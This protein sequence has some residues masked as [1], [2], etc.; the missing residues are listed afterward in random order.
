M[1]NVN[2]SGSFYDTHITRM[3]FWRKVVVR[4][5]LWSRRDFI[6]PRCPFEQVLK[7]SGFRLNIWNWL[8]CSSSVHVMISDSWAN[9]QCPRNWKL[10]NDTSNALSKMHLQKNYAFTVAPTTVWHDCF[11]RMSVREMPKLYILT[12]CL[13]FVYR[14]KRF[15]FHYWCVSDWDW[16]FN[17]TFNDISVM[18]RHIYRCAGG[19]KKKKLGLRSG[20]NR[21]FV[22]FSC[23]SKHQHHHVQPFYGYS[24]NFSCL[25]RRAWEYGGPILVSP[26]RVPT[27]DHYWS[28]L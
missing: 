20:S 28:S 9:L 12:Y 14:G 18:G 19:P 7:S 16:L 5:F 26:S 2:V 3:I 15:F 4:P 1:T 25:L 27:G 13:Y 23:P 6:S 24:E 8:C 17:V 10:V 11:S 22:G 21:D